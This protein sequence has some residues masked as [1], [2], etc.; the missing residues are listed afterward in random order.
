MRSITKFNLLDF[1][2]FYISKEIM[3][4]RGMVF[5]NQMLQKIKFF[6]LIDDNP[7]LSKSLGIKF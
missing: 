3:P 4:W 6:K 2:I 5:L 1:N 7:D